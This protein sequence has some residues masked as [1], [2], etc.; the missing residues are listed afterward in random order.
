M[1]EQE[2]PRG[3]PAPL[4]WHGALWRRLADMRAGDR[5]PH[6]LLLSGPEGVGKLDFARR[7]A[8]FLSC[9]A[10]AADGSPCGR[11]Q[12]CTL[13]QA[14][15]H[16]DV[17]WL[18]PEEPGKAI[19][20]DAVRELIGRSSLTTQ[21]RG[22]RVFLIAPA[23]AMNR[24]A[25]NALLKT[26]EEPVPSSLL[27]LVSSAPHR[28]PATILSRCQRLD[29]R[30][31]P[32]D[33]ARDWLAAQGDQGPLDQA[34]ALAGG[35]PLLARRFLAQEQVP[36][37]EQLVQELLALKQRQAN[38][39]QVAADWAG[40]GVAPVLDGLKRILSDLA[41]LSGGEPP[42]LFLSWHREDLHSL[43]KN[44][45]LHKLFQFMDELFRLERQMTHNLNPQMMMERLVN[46]WLTV[47]RPE[48]R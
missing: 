36:A 11:C 19:R 3:I 45:H 20:I 8:A 37:A 18:V 32:A 30:P 39:V 42:R 14:G 25:A 24:A 13:N 38:P 1:A 27:V 47:S 6:A 15:T 26:L 5:L 17:H 33:Q 31:V 44:I 46:D 34:L 22:L 7:L 2:T 40:R 12:A 10:P 35:A 4:P 16:P 28:L 29:F 21:A 9:E 48:K 43:R 41:G 23:D